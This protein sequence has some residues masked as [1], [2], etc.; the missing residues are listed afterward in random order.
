MTG[1][2]VRVDPLSGLKVIIAATR[3]GRPGGQFDLKPE[4]RTTAEPTPPSAGD[5]PPRP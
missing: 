4:P 5:T 3:A 2:E 1:N